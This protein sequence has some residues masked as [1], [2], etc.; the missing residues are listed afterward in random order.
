MTIRPNVL[1]ISTQFAGRVLN[2]FLLRG[3]FLLLLDSGS[4]GMPAEL[5]FPYMEEQGLSL[6]QLLQVVNSHAHAD[7]MGGNAEIK[8]AC[9]AVRI[10]AHELDRPWI[11]DHVLLCREHYERYPQMDVFGPSLRRMVLDWC[12]ADSVGDV[13]WRGGEV[14]DLGSCKL[15]VAHAPG[16]TPGN[17]VLLDREQG[18]LFEAETILSGVTGEAGGLGVPYYYDV[19]AYR[20]TL[21]HVAE[22]PWELVLS[23]HAQP[24]DRRAGLQAIQDSL[25]FVDQF[26]EQLAAALAGQKKSAAF[27]EVAEAMHDK[28][29]YSLDLGLALL[30]DTHLAYGART[31]RFAALPDGR[32]EM[33]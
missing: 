7:H 4:A 24:R 3:D 16:H 1:T 14:I 5:I 15:E 32:W 30:V 2:L 17:I 19:P 12:G 25:D 21:R 20:A 13:G 27:A 22:L 23:S 26:D 6:A 31:Q 33:T 18:I 28:Y 29:G 8:T 11:E 10:G 9:P